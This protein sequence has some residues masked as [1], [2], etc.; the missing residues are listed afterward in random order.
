VNSLIFG[1]HG[2]AMEEELKKGWEQLAKELTKAMGR[3][4]DAIDKAK[5]EMPDAMKSINEEY[6]RVQE[7]LDK[8]VDKLRK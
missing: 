2:G 5:T 1:G 6:L 4:S 3:L 8:A 7:M